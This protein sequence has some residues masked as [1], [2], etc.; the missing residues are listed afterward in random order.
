[1]VFLFHIFHFH[2]TLGMVGWLVHAAPKLQDNI[3]R[4][5]RKEGEGRQERGGGC[6]RGGGGGGG[7][8]GGHQGYL[9][10]TLKVNKPKLIFSRMDNFGYFFAAYFEDLCFRKKA[11]TNQT[12]YINIK[13]Q[14]GTTS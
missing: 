2:E 4:I 3:G 13:K 7:G 8:G 1:M 14:F 5:V 9:C 10:W 11:L 12:I 6:R